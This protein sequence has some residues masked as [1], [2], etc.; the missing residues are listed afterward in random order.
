MH[1]A[2][3]HG[4]R[5]ALPAPKARVVQMTEHGRFVRELP[6]GTVI[7]AEVRRAPDEETDASGGA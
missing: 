2:K 3:E 7:D 5:Y 6:D 1:T 4:E